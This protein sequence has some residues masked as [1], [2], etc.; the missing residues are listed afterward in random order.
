M[1]DA[2]K[3]FRSFC[4]TRA[5]SRERGAMKTINNKKKPALCALQFALRSSFY[6]AIHTHTLTLQ[7]EKE[8][9]NVVSEHL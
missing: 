1:R 7:K 5:R 9:E 8:R 4:E 3:V 2:L 6:I